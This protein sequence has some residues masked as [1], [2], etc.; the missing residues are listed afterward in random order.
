MLSIVLALNT[1]WF[2]MGFHAFFLRRAV[3]AK[4]L[5]PVRSQRE[6]GAFDAL[7]ESGRF[8]GGF[9]FALAALNLLLVVRI[10]IFESASQWAVLLAFNAAAHGSQFVGNIP[11]ALQNLRGEGTWQVF[12]GVM[13]RIFVMDFALAAFNAVVAIN[14]LL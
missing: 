8:L 4:I 14:Y 9:N 1:I 12:E 3:F 11:I 13:L 6:N 10:D 5:V 2:A 7:V